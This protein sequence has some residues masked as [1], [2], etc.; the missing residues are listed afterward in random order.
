MPV[1][2]ALSG[3]IKT[4]L[5]LSKDNSNIDSGLLTISNPLTNSKRARAENTEKSLKSRK[6]SA[7]GSA[8]SSAS[9][10]QV[11]VEVVLDVSTLSWSSLLGP[12]GETTADRSLSFLV[13]SY[14]L[15]ITISVSLTISVS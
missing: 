8:S 4:I 9:F 13:S 12:I 5:P 1:F 2:Q 11:E 10:S 3:E 7:V 6:G 14:H 15:I